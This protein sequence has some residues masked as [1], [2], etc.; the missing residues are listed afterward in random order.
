ML[1][2]CAVVLSIARFQ[3]H[4]SLH[5]PFIPDPLFRIESIR[6][7]PYS[8]LSHAVMSPIQR[9][10]QSR[11]AGKAES[12]YGF[13]HPCEMPSTPQP[14]ML[15]MNGGG[16][17][18]WRRAG[19]AP[20]AQACRP[21]SPAARPSPQPSLPRSLSPP[22]LKVA[23]GDPARPTAFGR[24]PPAG[25]AATVVTATWPAPQVRLRRRPRRAK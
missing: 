24:P 20:L 12:G 21:Y 1:P 2:S 25:R 18:P 6:L 15:P 14:L 23:A 19:A 4:A 9:S 17:R 7:L 5:P 22:T 8:P 11:L 13:V 16:A 10:S 3:C